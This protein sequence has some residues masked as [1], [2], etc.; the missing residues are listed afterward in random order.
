M[1]GVDLREAEY[2]GVCQ[3]A[4]EI[5]LYLLEVI[6]FLFGKCQTFILIVCLQVFDVYNRFGCRLVVNTFWSSPLYIR[7]SIGSWSAFSSFT[8]KYSSMRMMPSSPIFW[9]ISTAFCTP[10][11]NHLT[12]RAD[13]N[14]LSGC[15][16]FRGW[17]L[18]KA[19]RVCRCLPGGVHDY[20]LRQSRSWMG[21]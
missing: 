10:R 15:L 12:A 4:P 1:L 20:I 8:G 17:L 9:V 7:C 18:Q 13:E 2:F 5:F 16:H 21:F 19:S 6:H 3:R 14:V 11:S